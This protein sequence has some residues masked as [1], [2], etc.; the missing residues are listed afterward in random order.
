MLE[1]VLNPGSQFFRPVGMMI[2]W[3]LLHVLGVNPGPYHAV[4]WFI[5]LCNTGLVYAVLKRLTD[6]E[7][8][9]FAGSML[10]ASQAVFVDV[11]WNF[12]TIFELVSAAAVFGGVLFWIRE[13]RTWPQVLLYTAMYVYAVKAKETALVLPAIWLACDLISTSNRP[14]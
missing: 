2:Y 14:I 7:A 5:H 12:G 9:A 4:A 8:G 3:L 1:H 11:Y 6:S 10:F 13:N